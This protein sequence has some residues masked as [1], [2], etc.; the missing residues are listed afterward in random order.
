MFEYCYALDHVLIK[1]QAG[2]L[3]STSTL[4]VQLPLG[5]RHEALVVS[6]EDGTCWWRVD[7]T[8]LINMGPLVSVKAWV[9]TADGEQALDVLVLFAPFDVD[10][11]EVARKRIAS[12][13]RPI[14]DPYLL[15]I[16]CKRAVCLFPGD[17]EVLGLCLCPLAY[18]VLDAQLAVDPDW[19][20]F[21]GQAQ[22]LFDWLAVV[23]PPAYARWTTS[24]LMAKA[25]VHLHYA[26]MEQAEQ[27]LL[28]LLEFSAMIPYA[29]LIQTNLVRSSFLLADLYIDQG[30]RKLAALM[31]KRVVAYASAGIVHSDFLGPDNGYMKFSEVEVTLRGAKYAQRALA[32]LDQGEPLSR[33]KNA[34]SLLDLG[35]YTSILEKRKREQALCLKGGQS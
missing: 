11:V 23:K 8:W 25:Y 5:D 10:T 28:R 2:A 30:E 13:A 31:L 17:F 16:C 3:S 26:E 7:N 22:V 33:V 1:P 18:R 15:R 20:W 21:Q 12:T 32:M 4:L 9:R 6:A 35:G 34:Y 29:A 27:T 19:P 14:K 24:V